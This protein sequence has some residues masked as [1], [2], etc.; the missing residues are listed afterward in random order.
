MWEYLGLAHL[1]EETS[2][3]DRA[4]SVVLEILFRRQDDVFPRFEIGIKEVIAVAC[5]YLWWI[6]RRRTHD[7]V[8]PPMFL[9]KISVLTITSNAAK[10]VAKPSR[11]GARW[12]IPNP[13]QVEV[14]VDGSF[15]HDSHAVA[16]GEVIS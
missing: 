14:N 9:C 7:E 1:M 10:A 3:E 12:S 4:S 13:R 5:W 8:V 2:V 15:H 16:V 6:I 11:L